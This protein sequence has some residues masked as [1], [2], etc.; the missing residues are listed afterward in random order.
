MDSSVF[1]AKQLCSTILL[2]F[3]EDNKLKKGSRDDEVSSAA[4]AQQQQSTPSSQTQQ[5]QEPLA[6]EGKAQGGQSFAGASAAQAGGNAASSASTSPGVQGKASRGPAGKVQQNMAAVAAAQWEREEASQGAGGYGE[7]AGDG[8]DMRLGAGEL[9]TGK[10]L[11]PAGKNETAAVRQPLTIF[12]VVGTVTVA[13]GAAFM[14]A[15]R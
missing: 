3:V 10:D 12:A 2:Q 9:A 8:W 5:P 15:K 4:D 1:K 6:E 7:L 11:V 14:L 13:S